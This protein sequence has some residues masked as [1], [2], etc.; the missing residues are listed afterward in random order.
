MVA[1]WLRRNGVQPLLG[2]TMSL[3]LLHCS[4][5]RKKLILL[6]ELNLCS[7]HNDVNFNHAALVYLGVALDRSSKY[8]Q[9]IKKLKKKTLTRV[10]LL[11]KL[12]NAQR[13]ADVKTIRISTLALVFASAE[14][15][16][17]V[18]AHSAHAKKFEA[19]FNDACLVIS[20]NL[21]KLHC[22]RTSVSKANE[23]LSKW[24][25]KGSPTCECGFLNQ[26]L[27][28]LLWHCPNGEKNLRAPEHTPLSTGRTKLF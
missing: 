23:H 1:S 10:S 7:Y 11:K 22:L 14:Y 15:F 16:C 2:C 27:E 28:H 3:P 12:A 9:H 20:G 24:G 8:K 17:P 26:T 25:L 18:W 6:H 4:K 21:S 19:S 13:N 5:V